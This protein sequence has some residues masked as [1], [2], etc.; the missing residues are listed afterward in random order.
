[1]KSVI[2]SLDIIFE[3]LFGINI[4][5]LDTN[6]RLKEDLKLDS[7]NLVNLQVEIEDNF[8]IRFDPINMDLMSIFETIGSLTVFLE[9]NTSYE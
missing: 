5:N 6:N 1:M 2:E 8:N 9:R 3:D 7:I 4:F